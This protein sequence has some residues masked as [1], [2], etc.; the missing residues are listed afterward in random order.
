VSGQHTC[1]GVTAGPDSAVANAEAMHM[2]AR[3]H[4]HPTQELQA[5]IIMWVQM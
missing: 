3:H 5:N 4:S 2:L 1:I